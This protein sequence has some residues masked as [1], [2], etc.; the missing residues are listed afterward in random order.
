MAIYDIDPDLAP[1][2]SYSQVLNMIGN[3]A[4]VL[5]ASALTRTISDLILSGAIPMGTR[6]PTVRDLAQYLHTGKTTIADVWSRLSE[7]GLVMSRG[8][9]GT[10][11]LHQ[12]NYPHARRYTQMMQLSAQSKYVDLGNIITA[13]LP[14]KYLRE[15]VNAAFNDTDFNNAQPAD[16]TPMLAKACSEIWPFQGSDYLA[17]QGLPDALETILSSYVQ[18]GDTVLVQTPAVPRILDIL[19]SLHA[20]VVPFDT[21]DEEQSIVDVQ[22][23]M[24]SQPILTILQPTS[25]VPTGKTVSAHW[26]KTVAQIIRQKTTVLE[27]EQNPFLPI[28]QASFGQLLPKQTIRATGYNLVWGH[29]LPIAVIGSDHETI[30]RL[31]RRR[32]FSS[33]WVSRILQNAAAY[34][35]TDAESLRQTNAMINA[36]SANAE[37]LRQALRTRGIDMPPSTALQL[38]VPTPDEELSAMLLLDEGYIAYPGRFFNVAWN[39]ENPAGHLYLNPAPLAQHTERAADAIATAVLSI[40]SS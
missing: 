38:W 5:S 34:L 27:I 10:V 21:T 1:K 35:L 3:H 25:S 20:S 36:L 11:V 37:K 30:K 22:H 23:A 26:L 4:T 6:L 15:A 2:L 19:D 7:A 31:S 33:R 14:K 17:C 40:S 12:P 28:P 18:R 9:N 29:D 13:H 16:I 8:K 24:Y 32:S 39:D